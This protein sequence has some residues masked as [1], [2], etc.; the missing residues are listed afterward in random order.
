MKATDIKDLFDFKW[1]IQMVGLCRDNEQQMRIEYVWNDR[2]YR[3]EMD[4]NGNIYFTCDDGRHLSIKLLGMDYDAQRHPLGEKI[5][6]TLINQKK[7]F[8]PEISIRGCI[9]NQPTG[10]I[11]TDR[12][13]RGFKVILSNK[14][15]LM[16]PLNEV[17]GSNIPISMDFYGGALIFTEAG[18]KC[19]DY[20]IS[21][22]GKSLTSYKGRT[23]P[24]KEELKTL[25]DS[26]ELDE[27]AKVETLEI[28]NFYEGMLPHF[29]SVI[30]LRNKVLDGSIKKCVFDESETSLCYSLLQIALMNSKDRKVGK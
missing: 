2:K 11:E 29:Q 6:L 22:D 4:E 28:L 15:N 13:K 12:I 9:Y 25:Y 20:L 18:V 24:S 14:G 1:I 26:G 8:K 3:A 5:A 19:N 16:Y 21:N 7:E 23:L 17:E 27:I 10:E 30:E